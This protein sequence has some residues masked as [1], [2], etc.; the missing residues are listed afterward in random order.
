MLI[1]ALLMWLSK[2]FLLHIPLTQEMRIICL[3][4]SIIFGILITLAGAY[5]FKKAKTTVN[6]TSP[7]ST[8]ALVTSGIYQYTRNP[9]YLGFSSCLIGWMIFLS[10]P[11]SI[12]Y[13]LAFI[14]YMTRFQIEPEEK[15]LMSLFKDN[16]ISYQQ[17][18]RRWI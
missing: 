3:L 15:M 10:S 18:V 9:M 12:I 5:S 8:S 11:V 6:P 14:F 16:Y 2:P 17:Q 4:M 7:E 13:V 1:F